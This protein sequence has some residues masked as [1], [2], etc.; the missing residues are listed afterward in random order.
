MPIGVQGKIKL[1]FEGDYKLHFIWRAVFSNAIVTGELRKSSMAPGCSRV[2]GAGEIARIAA[3]PH[4]TYSVHPERRIER[5]LIGKY[6]AYSDQEIL[7][8]GTA[9]CAGGEDRSFRGNT[10]LRTS[11]K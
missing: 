9:P 10:R 1:Q 8:A 4:W 7:P 3:A 11:R 2:Q 6:E 5:R